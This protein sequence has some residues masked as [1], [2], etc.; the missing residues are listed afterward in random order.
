MGREKGKR[1]LVIIWSVC[2]GNREPRPGLRNYRRCWKEPEI[3]HFLASVHHLLPSLATALHTSAAQFFKQSAE[4][5]ACVTTGIHDCHSA[6]STSTKPT[7]SP[8][9]VY[10]SSL[11]ATVNSSLYDELTFNQTGC[12]T[13]IA[14]CSPAL[15]V[16][17]EINLWYVLLRL[18][19][20]AEVARHGPTTEQKQ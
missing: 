5:E 15:E 19:W 20:K 12:S 14:V 18:C 17:N 4:D 7:I 9:S 8:S 10:R 1:L 6:P 13:L 16:A 2:R 11:H 3:K